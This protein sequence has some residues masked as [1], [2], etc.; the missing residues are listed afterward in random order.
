MTV[1]NDL[2]DVNEHLLATALVHTMRS[3]G[4][5]ATF[6]EVV[7]SLITTIRTEG[8]IPCEERDLAERK[9]NA[10]EIENDELKKINSDY[11][12][13]IIRLQKQV[14]VLVSQLSGMVSSPP[15]TTGTGYSGYGT[16]TTTPW[17]TYTSTSTAALPAAEVA[18]EILRRQRRAA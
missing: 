15:V 4:N 6:E 11:E 5:G 1:A 9:L 2:E 8:W 3:P 12:A 17:V 18:A 14:A 16:T 13:D 10:A 7:V